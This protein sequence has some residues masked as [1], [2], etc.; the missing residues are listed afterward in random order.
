MVQRKSKK[1]LIIFSD[2]YPEITKNLLIGAE[3]FLKKKKLTMR[4]KE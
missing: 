2:F 1:I 3:T 4:K